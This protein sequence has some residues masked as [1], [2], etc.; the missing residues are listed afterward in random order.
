VL[1]NPFTGRVVLAWAAAL[2]MTGI[3][4]VAGRVAA[5]V[6]DAVVAAQRLVAAGAFDPFG[7]V[8]FTVGQ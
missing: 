6:V 4:P 8:G 2:Q 5:D 1:L 3:V 7:A